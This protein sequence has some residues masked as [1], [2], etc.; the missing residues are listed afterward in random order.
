[1]FGI[2]QGTYVIKTEIRIVTFI[3][4]TFAKILF[5]EKIYENKPNQNYVK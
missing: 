1:M 4:I 3:L 2:M 5:S